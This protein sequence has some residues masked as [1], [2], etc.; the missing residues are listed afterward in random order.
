MARS[1]NATRGTFSIPEVDPAFNL[2]SFVIVN[3]AGKEV[4]RTTDI[5]KGWDGTTKGVKAPAGLYAYTISGTLQTGK[6]GVKGTVTL[7]R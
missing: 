2:T 5:H 7:T 6:V 1:F 4:F 3:R